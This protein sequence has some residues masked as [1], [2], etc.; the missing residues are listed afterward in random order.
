MRSILTAA[1]A[2][3]FILSISSCN[4]RPLNGDEGRP[5]RIALIAPVHA[6]ELAEAIRLGAEAAAREYGAELIYADVQPEEENGDIRQ[7]KAALRSIEEGVSAVIIDPADE[8]VLAALTDKA[9]AAAVPVVALNGEYPV[10]GI[11]GLIAVDNEEAGRQAGAAMAEL[12]GGTGTVALLLSDRKDPGLAKREKGIRE[13]LLSYKGIRLSAVKAVCGASRDRC[14]QAV[15]QLLDQADVDGIVALEE[16]GAL[17]TADEVRRRHAEGAPKIVA[18]GSEFEQLELLQDG[19]I[20]K[21]VVQN[22]FSTGYLGV[23]QA[24]SLTGGERGSAKKQLEARLQTKLIDSENM[25]WM[26]NQKLLFPFVQ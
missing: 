3:A 1:A 8:E 25:F 12:L 9:A 16:Q 10:K 18:F 19:V 23:T 2:A 5:K 15:K 26:D 24:V 7:L 14:W 22:G 4:S 11:A 17:G 6:G 21:L 13:T 20:H